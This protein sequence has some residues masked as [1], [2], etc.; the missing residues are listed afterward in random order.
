[1]S[2]FR[3]K[4]DMIDSISNEAKV[5]KDAARKVLTNRTLETVSYLETKL[6]VANAIIEEKKKQAEALISI[7]SNGGNPFDIRKEL[8]ELDN[9][10]PLQNK[11]KKSLS[12]KQLSALKKGRK[13][14]KLLQK[15]RG[16][17]G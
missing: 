11:K 15:E 6:A 12:K 2:R 8:K 10:L 5:S 14:L 3:N 9:T 17:N 4:A 13:K 16:K 7:A 1:M